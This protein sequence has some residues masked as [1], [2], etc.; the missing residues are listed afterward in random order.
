MLSWWIFIILHQKSGA[1][2]THEYKVCALQIYG[3]RRMHGNS[4]N[5]QGLFALPCTTK[6]F[7]A[8]LDLSD[9]IGTLSI[10]VFNGQFHIIETCTG[11][12]VFR[13]R[14]HCSYWISALQ[15]GVCT[16]TWCNPQI[17]PSWC[18]GAAWTRSLLSVLF[19]L[20]TLHVRCHTSYVRCCAC[21]V[22][23]LHSP[24][25]VRLPCTRC[26]YV[27]VIHTFGVN[28]HRIINELTR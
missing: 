18:N 22:G 19:V 13:C 2:Q 1:V 5:Q 20:H 28:S 23:T 16:F 10:I 21:A 25:C 27:D 9:W 3:S 8:R 4:V 12:W 11:Y 7:I 24:K 14:V 6:P 26:M 15:E 17:I